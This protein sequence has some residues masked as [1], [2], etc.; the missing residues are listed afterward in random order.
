METNNGIF[1]NQQGK[2]I[3]NHRMFFITVREDCN[4]LPSNIG[5]FNTSIEYVCFHNKTIK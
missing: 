5:S 1:N 4:G 3:Y 2:I